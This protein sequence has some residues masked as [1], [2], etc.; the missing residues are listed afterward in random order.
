VAAHRAQPETGHQAAQAE[1]DPNVTGK[2]SSQL[3]QA[4]LFD[5]KL[6][7]APR[8]MYVRAESFAAAE[9]L[10]NAIA[11]HS[12]GILIEAAPSDLPPMQVRERNGVVF[13][14]PRVPR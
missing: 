4:T 12:S 8:S 1:G 11:A 6:G 3:F 5:A 13:M 7:A 10:A 9:Q 2:Y 14:V